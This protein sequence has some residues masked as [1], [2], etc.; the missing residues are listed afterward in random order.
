MIEWVVGYCKA[1]ECPWARATPREDRF[2]HLDVIEAMIEHS[3]ETGHQCRQISH[4]RE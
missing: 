1:E 3:E 2:S 4:Y